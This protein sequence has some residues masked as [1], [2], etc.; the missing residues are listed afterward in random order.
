LEIITIIGHEPEQEKIPEGYWEF[1]NLFSECI[2]ILIC[3]YKNVRS[4]YWLAGLVL[5]RQAI[6]IIAVCIVIWQDMSTNLPKF[7]NSDLKASKCVGLSK[8]VMPALVRTWGRLSNYHVHASR[9]LLGASF[10][11]ADQ[12]T[13]S[14]RVLIGGSLQ[15]EKSKDIEYTVINILFVTF[16]LQ[17]AIELLFWQVVEK[18]EFWQ[19]LK[20]YTDLD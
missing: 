11:S 3:S 19:A 9:H 10:L 12:I 15:A 4:G 16:Y 5:L 20:K 6:E 2:N 18:K 1:Y 17:A 8:K 14:G 7:Y 13:G